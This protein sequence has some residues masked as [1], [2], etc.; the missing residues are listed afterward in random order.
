MKLLKLAA[1][2][3][4]AVATL[5]LS[6]PAPAADGIPVANL[7]DF[8]GRTATVGKPYG[9][10]KV[11]A[12]KWLNAKGGINGKP[13]DLS[14]FDYSYEVPRAI[15]TYK[16]WKQE[17]VVAIQGWGTADTEALVSFVGADEIP[18]FSASYSAHLT[19][20]TGKGPASSKAAPY[21]F[22]MG[23]SYSDSVR[24]LI[25][26][27]KE[28]WQRKGGKGQPKYVHM[29][30]NHPYPNAPKKAGEEYAKEQGFTVLPSIQY[31]LAPGDFK[32]QCLTLKESGANYAFLANTSGAN[33]SLLKSCQTVGVDVQFLSNIW[34][35]D[36]NVM[37]AAGK[38][39]DGVVWVMGS[40][41]WGAD[42]PGIKLVH[43]IAKNADPAVTYQ[44]PHYIR[45][46]CSF[47]FMK[48]AME[49][50][51]KNG[52][53]TGPNIKKGMYQKKDWV[54]AGLEGVCPKG[55]WTA[56]DHRGFTQVLLYQGKVKADAPAD[57]DIA[58]LIADGTIGM[59][60]VFAIDIERKPEWL[61]W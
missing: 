39:A 46:V 24:A 55:T 7:V 29:G 11:D 16:Q 56:E 17:G 30:D 51:D 52:G 4:A 60:Q 49:W 10:A 48:E 44:L 38:A 33:I 40:A 42:V 54:P 18:F 32:A 45:G 26:W 5:A 41:P 1:V 21:N 61:G 9:Q 31:T 43:D 8:T 50:A 53:I 27:A 57:A 35:Y 14:T 12:V 47:Y 20:P 58:K 15:N 13:I 36:E 3:A 19:D 22:I 23:P 25:A 28:D 34:G 6:Q 59:D 37:K 2:T